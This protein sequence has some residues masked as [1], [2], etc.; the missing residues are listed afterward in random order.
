[1]MESLEQLPIS[2]KYLY[3]NLY[4]VH[5]N[6]N[7]EDIW[8]VFKGFDIVNVIKNKSIEGIFD[9]KL[10]SREEFIKVIAPRCYYFLEKPFYYRFSDLIRQPQ[11]PR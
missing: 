9:L 4:K 8:H 11:F 5:E 2:R 1:M 7:V 6:A 3:I 10:Q